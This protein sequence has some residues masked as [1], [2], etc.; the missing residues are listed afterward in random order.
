MRVRLKYG[1]GDLEVEIPEG[2]L[3]SILKPSE[4]PAKSEAEEIRGALE[5]PIGHGRLR[6]L[7]RRGMKV[8]LLVSDITRPCPSHKILP[9]VIDELNGAGV[10]DGDITIF[11]ANGMHRKQTTE[12]MNKLV[13]PGI[14]GRIRAVNHDS[15]DKANLEYVGRT[16]RGTDVSIN[17]Q[18]LDCDFTIGIA[19]VDIHYFAGYSGGGKSL[20]P[21][22]SSFETIQQNHSMMTLPRAEPG[23]VDGNPVREDIEEGARIAGMDYMVNVVLNEDKGIVQA[24]AGDFVE[25][26]RAAVKTNDLMYKVPI[27]RRADIVI[28]SAGG[29]PKDIN[30][31]QAQKA[32]DNALYAVKDGGTI[33]LL[34]ECPEGLGDETF[35]EWMMEASCPDDIIERLKGGF[36][37]G[38]HKAFAI[39]RLAKRAR[40]V[41]VSGPGLQRIISEALEGKGLMESANTVDDALRAALKAHGSDASIIIMPYAGS[42]LPSPSGAD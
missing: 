7:V 39:A 16:R 27:G 38:G 10:G 20:L 37:L 31:Y 18:V 23:V 24:V 2:N 9:H 12:D 17:K 42:T 41:A 25:A 5:R 13:G 33:I 15:K 6:D 14:L 35:E 29:F 36:A 19:N 28:A 40:I 3:L 1:K 30:L 8:A 26:H 21:G 34:A 11:F 4:L 22:V 32:L